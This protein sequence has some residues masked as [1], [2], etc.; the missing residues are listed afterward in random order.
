VDLVAEI[1]LPGVLG[2]RNLVV[3]V[4]EERVR[5]LDLLVQ[6]EPQIK[7]TQ[8]AADL[9]MIHFRMQQVV[10]VVVQCLLGE[11]LLRHPGT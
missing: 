5:P 8:A 1:L 2:C 9:G 7:A 6:M 4:A 11:M 3:Q 10:E